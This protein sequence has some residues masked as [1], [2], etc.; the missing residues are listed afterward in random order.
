MLTFPSPSFAIRWADHA[1]GLPVMNDRVHGP[2]SFL[3]N[4]KRYTTW[5]GL[6]CR[7]EDWSR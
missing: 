5:R 6:T 1:E 7:A 4:G 2:F 3:A